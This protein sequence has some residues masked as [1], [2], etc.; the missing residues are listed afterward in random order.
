[1]LRVAEA[2]VVLDMMEVIKIK[3]R[4]IVN[5]KVVILIDNRKVYQ[6]IVQMSTANHYV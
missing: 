5:K 3:A 2:I 6:M 1:M 4:H